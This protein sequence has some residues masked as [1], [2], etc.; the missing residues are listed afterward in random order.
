MTLE[1]DPEPQTRPRPQ[2]QLDSSPMRCW[3]EA[4][5]TRMWTPGLGNG[6]IIHLRVLLAK[7]TGICYL[8]IEN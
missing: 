6:E 5:L 2:Q 8:A 4:Q 3:K 1:E 7:F